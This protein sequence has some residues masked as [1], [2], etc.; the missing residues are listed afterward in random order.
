MNGTKLNGSN[1]RSK[2]AP[3]AKDLPMIC[4]TLQWNAHIQQWSPYESNVGLIAMQ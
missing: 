4:N 1:S 3:Y 2:N